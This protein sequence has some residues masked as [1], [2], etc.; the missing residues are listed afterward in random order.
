MPGL[1]DRVVANLHSAQTVTSEEL[2]TGRKS[3]RRQTK[4]MGG[5]A[6]FMG[7][8]QKHKTI[9]ANSPKD[10][11]G[12]P[13]EQNQ[14]A[15][16]SKALGNFINSCLHDT[17]EGG[18][19]LDKFKDSK[20]KSTLYKFSKGGKAGQL[21]FAKSCET[22]QSFSE[23]TIL[24]K[25]LKKSIY[26][27]GDETNDLK[28]QKITR[29]YFECGIFDMAI[30]S[31]ICRLDRNEGLAAIKL[32]NKLIDTAITLEN[33]SIANSNP[34]KDFQ[35]NVKNWLSDTNKYYELFL[36]LKEEIEESKDRILEKYQKDE[37]TK[38]SGL[39]AVFEFLIPKN[40]A[41]YRAIYTSNKEKS[42]HLKCVSFLQ[43]LC[44]NCCAE[45][46]NFMRS[47]NAIQAAEEDMTIEE[48]HR[49][50]ET[51]GP[52]GCPPELQKKE[53]VKPGIRT[54]NDERSN[55]DLV[56]ALQRYIVD[57]SQTYGYILID[58]ETSDAIMMTIKTLVDFVTGPCTANQT[59][60]GTNPK[61]LKYFS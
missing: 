45:F 32:L 19:F 25:L 5:M 34:S 18:S 40:M 53:V 37:R 55:I 41:Q 43:L 38:G 23:R 52:S 22:F 24:Y 16:I 59:M 44:D 4:A 14:D 11:T 61:L 48:S 27:T 10:N 57:M 3:G 50:L 35:I 17:M 39:G 6:K 31:L 9:V 26:T 15:V 49:P 46:Q 7:G 58:K 54:R 8:L 60:L 29:A 28:M 56:T 13:Q 1:F 12:T 33:K 51:C 2:K 47:Q 21:L 42:I 20:A 36:F 30:T